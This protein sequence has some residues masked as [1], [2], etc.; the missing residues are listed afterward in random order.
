[1]SSLAIKINQNEK[2]VPG[3]VEE[4]SDIKK[5]DRVEVGFIILVH[6]EGQA[7]T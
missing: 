5:A 3:S 2:T 7:R 4:P 1:M 6:S